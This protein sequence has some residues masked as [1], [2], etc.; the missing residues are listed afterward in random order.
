M[1]QKYYS[2]KMIKRLSRFFLF[3]FAIFIAA[4]ETP[5]TTP[6]PVANFDHQLIYTKHARCRMDCRHITEPEIKEIL[7]ANNINQHKSN[8]N[9]SRCPT[10]AYEGYSHQQ[11]HLRIV[12]AKCNDVWKVV[13]CIV[14]RSEERR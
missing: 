10:Y 13:T 14:L 12:I 7:A 4:C 2:L 5:T 8:E 6:P 3:G 11:Q 9:D 1:K